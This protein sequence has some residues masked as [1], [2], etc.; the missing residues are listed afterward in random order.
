MVSRIPIVNDGNVVEG[1][2]PLASNGDDGS[3]RKANGYRRSSVV[4]HR[5]LHFDPHRVLS[6]KGHYLHLSNGQRIFDAT[7]GAA[8]ACLGHGNER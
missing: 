1:V 3:V 6:A 2:A 7:G 5:S 4:L 8:V